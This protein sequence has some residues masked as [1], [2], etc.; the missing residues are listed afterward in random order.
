MLALSVYMDRFGKPSPEFFISDWNSHYCRIQ[1]ICWDHVESNGKLLE[2]STSMY[3]IL[4]ELWIHKDA[5]GGGYDMWRILS[6][7]RRQVSWHR[8]LWNIGKTS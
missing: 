6:T 8:H 5:L 1:F 4:S 2:L 7:H 3:D